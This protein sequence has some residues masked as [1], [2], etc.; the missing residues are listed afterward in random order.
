MADVFA[1]RV[2]RDDRDEMGD[3]LSKCWTRESQ[4]DDSG[5]VDSWMKATSVAVVLATIIESPI[6]M[7]SASPAEVFFEL[8]EKI[9][10]V[11]LA[12]ASCFAIRLCRSVFCFLCGCS[13]LAI[14][15]TLPLLFN[16]FPLAG[17]LSTIECIFKAVFVALS[18]FKSLTINLS[19]AEL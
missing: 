18:V 2:Y 8:S 13:V 11:L 19:K 12:A 6:E 9:I 4:S 3:S 17:W 1:N 14:A 10:V 15:P 16:R 7:I 5:W